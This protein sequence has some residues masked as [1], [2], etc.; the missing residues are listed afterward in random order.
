MTMRIAIGLD[1]DGPFE[2]TLERATRLR[3]LGF[4]SMWSS[5]IFGPDTLTVLA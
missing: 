1:T 3:E 2:R 5:Q 4:T